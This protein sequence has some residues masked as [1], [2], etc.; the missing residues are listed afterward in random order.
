MI[1][2]VVSLI[3]K[4]PDKETKLLII[5]MVRTVTDGK[6]FVEVE[7]ARVTRMLAKIKED[8][9]N[10]KEAADILQDLQVKKIIII[11]RQAIQE[12]VY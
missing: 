6:I 8:E 12:Y 2:E 10:V 3:E 9:G 7:R 4:T 5:D 1:Q 11:R